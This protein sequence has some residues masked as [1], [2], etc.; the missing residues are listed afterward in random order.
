MLLATDPEISEEMP[1][2]GCRVVV[3]HDPAGGVMVLVV[4]PGGTPVPV[5]APAGEPL[6]TAW[7]GVRG[8]PGRPWA[9]A[10]GQADVAGGPT[11]VRF[12]RTR[13]GA[14]A[15]RV[16]VDPAHTGGLW[17]AEV[18]GTYDAISIRTPTATRVGRLLPVAGAATL[19]RTGWPGG[20]EP[21]P[22]S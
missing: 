5:A 10:V 21:P 2:S 7:R 4:P 19:A 3:R 12:L 22:A 6:V 1:I 15:R 16:T 14:A 17:I 8:L 18:A 9:L 13:S 20:W 11:E